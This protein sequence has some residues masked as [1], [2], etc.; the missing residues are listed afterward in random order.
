MSDQDALERPSEN[1]MKRRARS[2]AIKES[3]PPLAWRTRVGR[4]DA[5]KPCDN[6]P[7][8][9]EPIGCEVL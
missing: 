7:P 9:F 4:A 8:A 5:I 6:S 2:A 3:C 1:V